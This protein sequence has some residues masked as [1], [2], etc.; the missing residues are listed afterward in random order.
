MGHRGSWGRGRLGGNTSQVHTWKG[1]IHQNVKRKG[2][3]RRY[4]KRKHPNYLR[5]VLKSVAA[6]SREGDTHTDV[7]VETLA[8]DEDIPDDGI[9]EIIDEVTDKNVD[10][11]Q[12]YLNNGSGILPK[13]VAAHSGEGD[14]GTDVL[15]FLKK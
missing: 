1:E 13:S 2:N 3:I 10:E 9:S 8:Q 15:V 5:K 6:K 11:T 4:I 12:G 7:F 14:T